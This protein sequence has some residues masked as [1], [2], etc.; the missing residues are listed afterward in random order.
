M[1]SKILNFGSDMSISEIVSN[2]ADRKERGMESPKKPAAMEAGKFPNQREQKSLNPKGRH[3]PGRNR[4][5]TVAIL[6]CWDGLLLYM[7]LRCF[8]HPVYGVVL[9]AG[10]SVYLG[11]QM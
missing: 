2:K 5:I 11:Y 3:A 8:V 9:V 1:I 10:V 4:W 6:L 7:I